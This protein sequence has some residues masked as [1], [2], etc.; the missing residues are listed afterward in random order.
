MGST[1]AVQGGK[2]VVKQ[3]LS[4]LK[5]DLP[6]EVP[7]GTSITE[8]QWKEIGVELGRQA[9]ERAWAVGDW[10]LLGEQRGFIAS[11][12]YDSAEEITGLDRGTLR[13]YAS[14]ARKVE[15]SRRRDDLGWSLHQAV[16]R[17]GADDQN[18][19]LR[20]AAEGK[21]GLRK[22]RAKIAESRDSSD[23]TPSTV[24]FDVAEVEMTVS[25]LR[26]CAPELEDF[27]VGHGDYIVARITVRR[28]K[29]EVE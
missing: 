17:F 7:E 23:R 10:L 22:L 4:L 20:K 14:V 5:M 8:E 29:R 9:G 13:N 18:S 24:T 12:N 2:D 28:P 25:D 15:A 1:L 6:W 19:W 26:R 16:T 11:D 21:W 27:L 3:S